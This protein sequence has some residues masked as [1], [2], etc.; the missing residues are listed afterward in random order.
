MASNVARGLRVFVWAG[1]SVLVVI[2][3]AVVASHVPQLARALEVGWLPATLVVVVLAVAA[4]VVAAAFPWPSPVPGEPTDAEPLIPP[5]SLPACRR[6]SPVI[7]FHS[8]EPRCGSTTLA[9]NLAVQVAAVGTVAGDRRPRPI[10]L[11]TAG[12]LTTS[13]GLDPAPL[14]NYFL[15]HRASVDEWLID[16]A[17]ETSDVSLLIAM[18]TLNSAS[19]SAA[20]ADRAWERGLEGKL[21]LIVDQAAATKPMPTS[22]MSGLLHLAVVPDD[23]VVA[24][25]DLKGFP[26]VLRFESRA[27]DA[28]ARFARQLLPDLMNQEAGR[29]A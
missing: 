3:L 2:A 15:S 12:Q 26:W 29:A 24:T 1:L 17:V 13:L 7:A 6:V 10:C 9:F 18:P 20:W 27:R 4:S 22:L 14:A 28:L 5:P 21:A 23:R 8:L 25:N 16:V 11:L 19:A